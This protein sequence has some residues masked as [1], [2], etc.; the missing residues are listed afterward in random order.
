MA[1]LFSGA[2]AQSTPSVFNFGAHAVRIVV[3]D[4]EP[5]FVAAD[6]AAA[7]GYLTAKDAARNLSE[8]QKGG[9]ILP[10]P[11]G[12]QR[13]TIINESGLYRLVLR[14]RKPEAEKFSDWVT[15]EVLPSIR[16]TGQYQRTQP[17]L[18]VG[19]ADRTQ[20]A[21]DIASRTAAEVQRAVFAAVMAGEQDWQ[22][23]RWLLSY[24]IDR[25]TPAAVKPLSY[26]A[27]VTT[28]GRLVKDVSTGECTRSSAD[29]VNM[30]AACTS[31]L[32]QRMG[33]EAAGAKALL[34]PSAALA[35]LERGVPHA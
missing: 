31:R 26:D 13:V 23:G 17:A 20:A 29:L 21:F 22:Y 9:H 19:D 27:F 5:W 33:Q 1:D 8:H 18:P 30:A 35:R 24:A 11:G 28:W 3:R 32:Q 10:T 16:K 34:S 12:E 4:G 6:V 14:S 25:E 2:S 15:G 7:L